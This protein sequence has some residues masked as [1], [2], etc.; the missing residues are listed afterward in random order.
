VSYG[1][2]VP[3]EGHDRTAYETAMRRVEAQ[4]RAMKTRLGQ[5]HGLI[6]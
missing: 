5:K 6:G 1:T 4:I 3:V 2:L